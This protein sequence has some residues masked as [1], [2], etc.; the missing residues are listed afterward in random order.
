MDEGAEQSLEPGARRELGFWMCLALVIGNIIGSGVFLLPAA[1]APFGYNAIFG[2]MV[3]IG[4]AI[5]L[6][7]VFASLSRAIPKAGGPYVYTRAAFGEGAGFAVAWSYWISVWTACAAIAVAA[8]SYLSL[9]FPAAAAAPAL[10]AVGCVWMLTIVNCLSIRAAG[11]VQVLTTLL[12]LLPLAAAIII[13]AVVLGNGAP[14]AAGP[15]DAKAIS[16]SAVTASA[17]L[18]LWAMLGFESAA[19]SAR[20]VRDPARTV[21]RATIA[22]TLVAGVVYLLACTGIA[23][24]LP[25]DVAAQSNAPFADFAE[26]YVGRNVAMAVG[27]FA[28]ISALGA[29]NG[30]VLV[31]GELPLAM[32]RDGVF[33]RWFAKTSSAGTPVR[34]QILSSSLITIL[35]IANYSRSMSE[36][37]V[38]MA[39]LSTAVTLIAYLAC[40]AAALR[41]MKMRTLPFS[42]ALAVTAI[43]GLI[44][45]VWTLYGA[46]AEAV[47]WGAVLLASGIPLW[48]LHRRK[49]VTPEAGAASPQE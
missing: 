35:V 43:L 42:R 27:L 1:L 44:Y 31:Q 15:L 33:P 17:T 30:W 6:A 23:L 46:G 22:G 36:L 41:L 25:A 19:V 32:A 28:A 24:L 45:S 38:F 20:T 48:L 40:S 8:V 13:S 49:G 12:K 37:F 39:L 11:T 3:T 26:A 18:T 10:V 14:V 34:V 21:P 29:L 4:G 47:G 7:F 9:F 5:C 2:W 16:A